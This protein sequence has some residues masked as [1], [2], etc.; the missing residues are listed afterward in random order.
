MASDVRLSDAGIGATRQ[1]TVT[2]TGHAISIFGFTLP[3]ITSTSTGPYEGFRP[4]PT[5]P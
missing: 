5:V 4:D 3:A 2:V 1:V